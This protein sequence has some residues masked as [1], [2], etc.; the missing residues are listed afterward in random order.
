MLRPVCAQYLAVLSPQM[1][2]AFIETA[3]TGMKTSEV[4]KLRQLFAKVQAS[5]AHLALLSTG[6]FSMINVLLKIAH[7]MF[8]NDGHLANNNFLKFITLTLGCFL[9]GVKRETIATQVKSS[10]QNDEGTGVLKLTRKE[11]NS[12]F[13]DSYY[14]GTKQFEKPGVEMPSD[15]QLAEICEAVAAEASYIKLLQLVRRVPSPPFT[16]YRSSLDP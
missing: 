13:G 1:A 4:N 15:A 14:G 11:T 2:E 3:S 5:Q 8:P 6:D 12:V 16:P 10:R 9:A 7:Q